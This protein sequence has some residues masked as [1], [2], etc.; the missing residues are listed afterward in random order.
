MHSGGLFASEPATARSVGDRKRPAGE[1]I[2]DTLDS[3]IE[4]HHRH[5][6][7][8]RRA[9]MTTLTNHRY[10]ALAKRAFHPRSRTPSRND[11]EYLF[12]SPA[13]AARLM[14]AYNDSLAGRNMTRTTLEDFRAFV[15][16]ERP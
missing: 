9:R 16:R 3:R 13:N 10:G 8:P 6:H 1:Q 11:D 5:S 4:M 15:H 14:R 12:R 7:H 2:V